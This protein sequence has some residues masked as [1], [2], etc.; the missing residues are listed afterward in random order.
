MKTSEQ[1]DHMDGW[2]N[3]SELTWL[4]EQIDAIDLTLLTALSRR[5]KISRSIVELKRLEGLPILDEAR[6]QEVL[7]NRQ[8]IGQSM[9]LSKESVHQ[10]FTFI[11]QESKRIQGEVIH[12]N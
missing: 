9:G 4:R 7:T 10:L 5:H 8:E 3:K 2:Q 12:E 6:E 1:D 11:M